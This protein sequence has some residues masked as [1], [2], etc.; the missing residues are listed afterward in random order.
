MAPSLAWIVEGSDAPTV[1]T[2]CRSGLSSPSS[3]ARRSIAFRYAWAAFGSDLMTA[4][5]SE[6]ST[7]STRSSSSCSACW[8]WARLSRAA[9]SSSRPTDSC[10]ACFVM[11]RARPICSKVLPSMRI[12]SAVLR[13]LRRAASVG[14]RRVMGGR[15]GQGA[16]VKVHRPQDVQRVPSRAR[17]DSHREAHDAERSG[18]VLG[19]CGRSD[20]PLGL[21]ARHAEADREGGG[22]Q[23]C[24]PRTQ[25]CRL[26]SSIDVAMVG[27]QAACSA[28][29]AA[30]ANSAR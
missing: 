20:E 27:C 18:V 13:R 16:W 5:V 10:A 15:G 1:A 29:R 11:P 22:R 12:W 21:P 6:R 28:A 26:Q 8:A 7:K 17:P 30:R 9:S 23:R 2:S 19:G 14:C 4:G 25:V 24:E 3:F